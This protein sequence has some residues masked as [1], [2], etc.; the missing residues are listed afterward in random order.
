M[1]YTQTTP[2]SAEASRRLLLDHSCAGDVDMSV[3]QNGFNPTIMT[4]FLLGSWSG[5]L[6][7][8]QVVGAV[9]FHVVTPFKP[10]FLQTPGAPPHPSNN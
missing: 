6:A 10:A 3:L 7:S 8:A 5:V 4:F 9:H 2:L 1:L